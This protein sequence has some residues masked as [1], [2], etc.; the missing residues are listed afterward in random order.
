MPGFAR[1]YAP[2]GTIVYL[3]AAE[4]NAITVLRMLTALRL[5]GWFDGANGV[6]IG[7]ADGPDLP[8]LPL[9]NGALAEVHRNGADGSIVQHLVP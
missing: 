5:A 3:E 2:E 6:L 9:V 8:E 1:K 7:R 4:C